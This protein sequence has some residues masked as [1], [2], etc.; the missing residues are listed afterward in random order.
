MGFAFTDSHVHFW[1]PA[2]LAYPWLAGCP[3]IAGAHGPDD[4]VREAEGSPPVKVVFIQAE[5]ARDQGMEELA[6]VEGLAARWPWIAAIVAFC[7]M[8]AGGGTSAT[9]GALA[10]KPLVRGVRH[11]IQGESDPGFC[12]SPSFVEG[13]QACGR[14][15]FTFDLCVRHPQLSSVVELV[16]RCPGTSFILDHAG[17]PDLR[18]GPLESWKAH[19]AELADLPNVVCKLSGL[20]NE[21]GSAAL[22]TGRF[23]PT[24]AH[25]LETF[26]PSRL[27]FG[28]DWPVMKLASPYP[29]WLT[30]AR[31][32]LSSLAAAEQAAVFS[33]NAARVY[34]LG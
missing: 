32:L 14:Q 9:L 26:G 21:A 2:R 34:R 8:D 7:P 15:D 33:G 5:C 30:M 10:G 12:L 4:L 6:W 23:V 31:T 24:I 1:D 19:I 20:P 18:S 29:T 22:D 11:L 16:S 27:L 13:V 25:L 3:S 28:S 17:K